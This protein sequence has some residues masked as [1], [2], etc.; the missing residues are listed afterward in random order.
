[1]SAQTVLSSDDFDVGW[2][3]W[4]SGGVDAFLAPTNPISATQ[5]VNI[6]DDNGDA[7]SIESHPIDISTFGSVDITLDFRFR[8]YGEHRRFEIQHSSDDGT[9]WVTVAQIY[10]NESHVL[11]TNYTETHS[12]DLNSFTFNSH[13]IFRIESFHNGSSKDVFIDNIEI[14]GNPPEPEISVSSNTIEIT[15]NDNI[16]FVIDNTNYGSA[17]PG[18]EMTRNFTIKNLG[19]TPLHISSVTLSNPT[20][21]TIVGPPFSSP[22]PILGTT[23]ISIKFNSLS[24]GISSTTVLINNEDTDESPFNFLIQAEASISFFDSDNDGVFDN[25]DIDDDNDGIEDYKEELACK[26]SNIAVTANYKFLNE[27]F[28]LGP[29]AKINT[30]YDAVTTYFYEDGTTSGIL[31]NGINLGDGEYTV[32]YRA[33]DGDGIDDTPI[34]E[35]ADWAD[36]YWY[37]GEDHTDGDTNGRMAFF[38]AALEPGIFYTARITGALPNVPITYSFWALNLD[39]VDAPCLNGCP[40]GPTWDD[41]PRLKPDIRIEFRDV[42]DTVLASITTGD[43]PPSINGDPTSSWHN[44]T[45]DLIFPVSEFNVFFYNNQLGGLGND[46]ALDDITITQTL[47]DTDN[48]GVAN[49]FDLDSDNDGIPDVVEAGF[50]TVSN[51]KGLIDTWTDINENG[52]HDAFEGML[53]LDSDG[54]GTPNF[55]DLD[56]DND[57]IFD[58]DESGAGNTANIYFQNGDGDINGDGVGDGPDT[59]AIREKDVDSD[60]T[61]EYFTDGILDIYDYFNGNT[62]GSG[63][64]NSNQGINYTD[65]TLDSDNDGNA[66]YIDVYNNNTSSFDIANTLYA[67]L[68]ANN[69]GIIDDT[70]DA[71]R[72]GLLDVF[73]TNDTQFGS[74]RD[75][76]GKLQLYFDGRNDYVEDASVMNNLD[77]ASIMGWI[78]IDPTFYGRSM[79]FGQGN[80]EIEIEDYSQPKV[81]ARVNGTTLTNDTSTHPIIKNQWLHLA[82]IYDGSNEKL[83]LYLNGQEIDDSS[84]PGPIIIPNDYQFTLGRAANVNDTDSYFKGYID[85]VRVFNK[86]LSKEELQKIVYQ[87][88]DNNSNNIRGAIIPRDITTLEWDNLVRYYRLDSYKNDIT[89]DQTTLTIDEATGAKLYNIKTIEYQSAPMPFITQQSN[90]DLATALTI[91]KDGVNGNDAVTYDWSIVKIEHND[92][93]FNDNQRHLGLFINEND[94]NSNPI[95]YQVTNDSELNIS[96]YLKLDGFIDLEGDSQLVQGDDSML[97]PTSKGRIEIDQQGTADNFTYNYWSSPVGVVSNNSNNNNYSVKEVLKDGSNPAAPNH[98]NWL[99]GYDGSNTTPIGL[100]DYWIWKRSN[101]PNSDYSAWQHVRKNGTLFTGEG[102]TLKGSGSGSVT[103]EQNYVFTGKPNNGD[104]DLPLNAGNDYLIGNPYPSAIDANQFITDNGPN[105]TG[106]GEAPSISGDLYFW[107]HWGGGSHNLA[108]YR[109]GYATYNLSG[110]VGAPSLGTNDPDIATGGT[111]TKQPARFIPVSQGFFVL[112][113]TT[114]TLKF[115]NG[116]RIYKKENPG[117]SVFVRQSSNSSTSS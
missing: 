103:E 98:I 78:K 70:L 58:V 93:T 110:G 74:P 111:P 95:E 59:D 84:S 82:L 31:G 29:R 113:K 108:D 20:D 68:D 43:I 92:I 112:G 6:Q 52:M 60:G 17:S 94:A 66:D 51:G 28:G 19:T 15:N 30:T 116:Q 56:S 3:H 61:A 97:D 75:L 5:V 53:L 86:V 24:T 117:T 45:A 104:V 96:W 33:G 14:T 11:N 7:S 91:V 18:T 69:N 105:S 36:D 37:T 1:V 44:F 57:S 55:I 90:E 21:F 10:R 65:H 40:G 34:E 87:E 101:Q 12:L 25:I 73:D 22:L 106:N 49:V 109:G 27:T 41:N 79:V 102:F 85:E 48:D 81:Y 35:I 47:C 63:Y 100:A 26:N 8:S 50:S 114:G 77:Q 16:P 23:S 13:A 72:D 115:N 32:Y 62:M 88:I 83:K 64:G 89:D 67:H 2:G 76:D 39:T 42:N 107:R 80:I 99:N 4:N 71:D 38:N 46:L 9:T 54:D